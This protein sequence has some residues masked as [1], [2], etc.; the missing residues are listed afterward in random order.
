M[1][2]RFLVYP[3]GMIWPGALVQCA[4]F[5]TLHESK[6]EDELNNVTRWKMS[7]IRLLLY[8]SVASFVYYWLP[9]YIFPL[10]TAFSFLCLLKPTNLVFSQITGISGLGVGSVHLDWNSI[11]AFLGSPIVVP[12]WAQLNILFG[13]V[14]LVWIVVPIMYYTNTWGSK[15]FPLGTT[16]LY[17]ADGSLYDITV[18]L[19]QNSRLNETA[20]KQYGTIRLTVM[21]ALAYGPTFAALTACIVHTILFHG[22]EIIRQFNMSITE[23]MNEVHAKLMAKYAEA[24][25]WWYTIVFCVNFVV[26]CL[27][28]HFG[29]LMP[30]YWLFIAMILVFILILP[31]G[32]VQALSNQQ[33]GLNVFSELIGG[34]LM[35]GHP[36]G[37]G[38]FKVYVYITEVQALLMIQDLKLGHYMKVPPRI[39]F[40][41]QISSAVVS[42]AVSYGF[43]LFLLDSVEGIC[44][45]K[46]KDWQCPNPN[47]FYTA[48]VIWGAVGAQK[49]FVTN[50]VSYYNVFWFFP[51]GA[52]LPVIQWLILQKWPSQSWLHYVHFPIMFSSLSY[53][54]PAPA[55]NFVSWLFLGLVFN[56]VVK[57]YV[58]DW[59]D[60]YAYVTSAALDI[61]VAFSSLLIFL[62]LSSQSISFP[63]WWGMG[64]PTY[65]GCPLSNANYSGIIPG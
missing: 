47:V 29:D 37:N 32:I 18:V 8:V 57:K 42:C 26:A 62:A 44:T 35:K 49:S 13:F 36:I 9:G 28:C 43:G 59:W 11:T 3:S 30:W 46:S 54:I 17:R 53:L 27:V 65:D 40:F 38:T 56:Y 24:P 45:A 31:I 2:R 33:L 58:F 4:F 39:M 64:G 23:A 21:F 19:D 61:G 51:L 14:V 16:E 12:G 41:A 25:E 52:I 1:L 63:N 20:Y 48:S 55:G 5:R 15:A 10:L 50:D 22:K 60:R 7:R 34:Y 6:E